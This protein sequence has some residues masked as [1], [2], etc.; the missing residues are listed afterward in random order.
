[1][2]NEQRMYKSSI[3]AG[4]GDIL[5][6]LIMYF[7]GWHDWYYNHFKFFGVLGIGMIIYGLVHWWLYGKR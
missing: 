2:K 4:I 3:I 5:V 1:M 7:T 6:G